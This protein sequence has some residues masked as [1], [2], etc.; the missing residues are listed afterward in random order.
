MSANQ[1]RSIDFETMTY[2]GRNMTLIIYNDNNNV[3]YHNVITKQED[4]IN[5]RLLLHFHFA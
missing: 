1:I 5:N 3:K 2:Y 4:T